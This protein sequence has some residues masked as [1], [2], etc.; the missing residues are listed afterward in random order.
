MVFQG[1]GLCGRLQPKTVKLRFQ[2]MGVLDAKVAGASQ[3]SNEKGTP[4]AFQ[5]EIAGFLALEDFKSKGDDVEMNYE[6]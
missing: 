2:C 5:T 4:A 1:P 3:C 6:S